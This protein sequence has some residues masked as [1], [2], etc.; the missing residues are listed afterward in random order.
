VELTR[1]DLRDFRNYSSA[2]VEFAAGLNLVVGGNGQGK[3]NLLEAVYVLCALGS[4][5]TSSHGPMI[6]YGAE[7]AVI[8]GS[9]NARG[10]P[11]QVD[12]EIRATGGMRVLINK[13]GLRAAE[14]SR[15]GLTSILFSPEDLALIKGGPDERRRFMDQS[16][17]QIRPLAAAQK[18]EFDRVLKQRNGAL[19]AAQIRSRERVSLEV[20]DEQFVEAASEIVRNRLDVLQ[21]L[22]PRLAAHYQELASREAAPR[23]AYQSKWSPQTPTA[24]NAADLLRQ[25]IRR[26]ATREIERGVSLVGPQ[27]DDLAIYLQEQDARLYASQ[28]EQRSLALSLRLAQRDAVA[29]NRSEEP[30]LLLDDVFSELDD[31]RRERLGELVRSSGQVIVTSTAV[32]GLPAPAARTFE[33]S[34]GV[35]RSADE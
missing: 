31:V 19:K 27:R 7:R 10:R 28:G 23:I 4:H 5:R 2:E 3:T 26:D 22:E 34:R 24:E 14:A 33:V 20:W 17:A 25:A 16:A 12:A 30:I 8:R 11:I 32:S 35:V 29:E 13:V 18:L 6:A 21:R 9:G 1:L 15:A